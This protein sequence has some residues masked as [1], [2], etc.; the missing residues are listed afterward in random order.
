M[1]GEIFPT[2]SLWR[3]LKQQYT[4]LTESSMKHSLITCYSEAY[5]T[6]TVQLNGM[7]LIVLHE[8]LIY[9]VFNRCC[10]RIES[11]YKVIIGVFLQ[12]AKV[13]ALMVIDV[14]SRHIYLE[15]NGYNATIQCLFY[16]SQGTLSTSFSYRWLALPTS[17]QSI[18]V[19]FII[20]GVIEFVSAQVPY[21]M[22]G[23]I[24]GLLYSLIL[25][26]AASGLPLHI[27]FSHKLSTWGTGIISCGFW[28]GLLIVI[29]ELSICAALLLLT[30]WYKKRK[31]EDVLP[32]EHFFA[33]RYYSNN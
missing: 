8:L 18:S 17:L 25:L 13:M 32:N 2:F 27:L 14:V 3:A 16:Q 28:Y 12:I 1:A 31:R 11:L 23:L 33:E 15:N 4:P 9:P 30:R 22:K 19:L 24:I 26:S 29:V 7:I 21:Y 5:F 10:P 20:I 6:N